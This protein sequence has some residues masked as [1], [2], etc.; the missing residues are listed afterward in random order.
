MSVEELARKAKKAS[1][2]IMMA[3]TEKKNHI[4][5]R[6]ANKL[7]QNQELILS[8]NQMDVNA[9]RQSG[10]KSSLLDRLLLN[11][12]RIEAMAAGCEQ[13]VKLDD[14][15]GRIIEEKTR[16][17]GLQIQCIRVPIGVIGM[18]YEARPNVTVDAAVLCIKSG[19]ACILRGGK[20]AVRS[21]KVLTKLMQDALE[22]EGFEREIIGFVDD[23][24]RQSAVEM[25]NARGLIDLLIP[26]GGAGL[27]QTVVREAKI[28]VIETGVGNCHIFV[29]EQADL[30]KAVRILINAKCSR[31][32]VCNAAESMLVH[33]KIAEDFFRLLRPKLVENDVQ[34]YGC[35]RT[36]KYLG[37]IA[38]PAEEADYG[39]EYLEK[40][41]SCKV[42]DSL[43]EAIKHISEYGTGHSEA[44]ITEDRS[45]AEVFLKQI[46]AAA[47]YWNAS[48]RFTDG[49][50][51]GLGAEI[52]IS[53]QKM[54]A[55][56][57]MG[58]EALTTVKYQIRGDGQI[59]E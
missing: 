33:E 36:V 14:P 18:I 6:I 44:I 52:G 40:K 55:R 48:T 34:V 3:D 15:V 58:L 56:G 54:H 19:N 1:P 22:E 38:K 45:H 9:A 21:G 20:E 50:E 49:G 28:P 47:V 8:E 23:T 37:D 41:I 43:Q 26:R 29:D 13:I 57:P 4:L 5:L 24:T 31:P 2:Q 39:K 46:D 59:R 11:E 42:V 27:I 35:E 51:F 16:P 7:R 17:N 10:M 12:S 30:E 53:T 32:S 25:M